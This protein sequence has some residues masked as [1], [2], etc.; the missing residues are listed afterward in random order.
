MVTAG[1]EIPIKDMRTAHASHE[2]IALHKFKKSYYLSNNQTAVARQA[3]ASRTKPG[4]GISRHDIRS[5]TLLLPVRFDRLTTL[6]LP[7]VNHLK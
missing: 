4:D 3:D 2:I 1:K 7:V 5:R 6:L